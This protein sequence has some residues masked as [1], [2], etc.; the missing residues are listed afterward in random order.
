MKVCR[1]SSFKTQSATK[2][3]STLRTERITLSHTPPWWLP[4]G[5]LKFQTILRLS[6]ALCISKDSSCCT[7]LRSS[8]SAPTKLE[9]LSLHTSLGLE[10]RAIKQL[11]ACKNEL[12]SRELEI[13]KCTARIDVHLIIDLNYTKVRHKFVYWWHWNKFSNLKTYLACI[14]MTFWRDC[15][16]RLV[17]MLHLCVCL[18]L[19]HFVSL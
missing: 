13:S 1:D 4:A 18:D 6:M 15:W 8:L 7:A 14:S 12:V 11:K 16:Q 17:L 5:G 2:P 10:R 9:P 3:Y 19:L